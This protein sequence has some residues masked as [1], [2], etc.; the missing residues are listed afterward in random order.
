[1]LSASF[2]LLECGLWMNI[3]S[4]SVHTNLL[5]SVPYPCPTQYYLVT[6]PVIALYH[7]SQIFLINL[8]LTLTKSDSFSF[9]SGPRNFRTQRVKNNDIFFITELHACN[10]QICNNTT[11]SSS[12]KQY[13]FIYTLYILYMYFSF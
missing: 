10:G 8:S 11:W 3:L 5:K 1:M 6:I 12:P 9:N 13:T 4:D 7:S 2:A